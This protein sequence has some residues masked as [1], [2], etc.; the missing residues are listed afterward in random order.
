MQE[1]KDTV[2][3]MVRIGYDGRVH[4]TFRGH[5]AKGRFENEVRVLKYLEEK[6]C[7]FVPKVLEADPETLKLVTTNCGARVEHMSEEKMKEVFGKLEQYGVR[8]EDAFLRNITY[9]ARQG[10]FCVID[11]EFAT[12]LDEQPPSQEATLPAPAA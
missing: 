9:N 12:L 3:A 7:D 8:H 6:G 2:R 1:V 4:K 10:R 5:N 11:F